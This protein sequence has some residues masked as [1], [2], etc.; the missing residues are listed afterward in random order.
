V[1]GDATATAKNLL[2]SE[3]IFRTGIVIELASA[4]AFALAVIA[5]YRLLKGINRI[6]AWLMVTFVLVSVPISF[7]N[8]LNEIAALMLVHGA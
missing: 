6:Y 7:V 2:A 8:V 5:L 3:T 1:S 4:I